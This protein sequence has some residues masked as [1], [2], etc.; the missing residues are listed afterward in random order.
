M[1]DRSLIAGISAWR[2]TALALKRW[3]EAV[4][5]AAAESRKKAISR[6]F[7][8]TRH[9]AVFNPGHAIG[10][11]FVHDEKHLLDGML[12]GALFATHTNPR[13]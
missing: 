2:R 3:Y 4:Y 11:F 6:P 13:R 5:S 1:L 7:A 9:G 12:S 10:I 8:A